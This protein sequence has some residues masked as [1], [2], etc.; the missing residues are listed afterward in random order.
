MEQRKCSQANPYGVFN[1]HAY[2]WGLNP[3]NPPD[4][5]FPYYGNE[6]AYCITHSDMQ[7]WYENI[8]N[9]GK[10]YSQLELVKLG[11]VYPIPYKCFRYG[12]SD[13]YCYTKSN[14][15]GSCGESKYC[16]CTPSGDPWREIS[17]HR[18]SQ[19]DRNDPNTFVYECGTPCQY[20]DDWSA[21]SDLGLI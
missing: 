18:W 5:C 3:A 17:F 11:L 16:T 15:C 2:G 13:Q 12:D 19:P 6:D 20:G 14:M 1:G 10:D 8:L 21:P 7:Y 4:K 9:K